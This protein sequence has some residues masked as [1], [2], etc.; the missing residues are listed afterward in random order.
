MTD[1]NVGDYL[2]SKEGII[3]RKV[4]SSKFGKDPNLLTI[5]KLSDIDRY[6][7]PKHFLHRN[8]VNVGPNFEDVK[9]Y[10]LKR[11]LDGFI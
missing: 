8:Y 2:V 10:L 7:I 9:L 11:E 4:V 5:R 3:I 1:Y 6:P